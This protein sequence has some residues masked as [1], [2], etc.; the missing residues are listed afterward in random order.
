MI[1][2]KSGWLVYETIS[3]LARNSVHPGNIITDMATTFGVAVFADTP[4]LHGTTL[5]FLTYEKRPW[6]GG[7]FINVTW[8]M[9]ELI[10]KSR[11]IVKENRL[12]IT[13]KY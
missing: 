6:V 4:E 11:T 1:L 5:A 9:P 8:D 3:P 2:S 7:R 10:A 13:I 12:R